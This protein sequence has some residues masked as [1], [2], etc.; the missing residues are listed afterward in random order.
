VSVIRETPARLVS[1]ATR[2]VRGRIHR[3]RRI[4]HVIIIRRPNVRRSTA[5]IYVHV[6]RARRRLSYR[7]ESTWRVES[8]IC[9]PIFNMFVRRTRGY[10]ERRA[11]PTSA[12]T[13][14]ARRIATRDTLHVRTI[15]AST[16]LAC[17]R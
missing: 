14:M 11:R 6:R 5:L 1:S 4:S 10:I 15:M 3:Y 17:C 12:R 16:I 9:R 8:L 13:H 7:C 2:T